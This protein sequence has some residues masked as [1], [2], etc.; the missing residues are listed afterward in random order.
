MLKRKKRKQRTVDTIISEGTTVQGKITHETSLRIDG[1][2]DGEVICYGDVYVGATGFIETRVQANNI[3]ISGEI[4]GDLFAN[5]RVYIQS[6]GK[7]N[8]SV[9]TKGIV[10]EEG[11]VL[12]GESIIESE[13]VISSNTDEQ[14]DIT[15][16]NP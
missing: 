13:E 16:V 5:E 6:K 4:H 14:E 15:E 2:V 11:G 3:I 10:I 7:V 12:N 1:K 9:T 8:G